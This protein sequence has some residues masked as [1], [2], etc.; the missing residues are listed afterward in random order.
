MPDVDALIAQATRMSHELNRR[1]VQHRK[2]EPYYSGECPLPAAVTQARLTRAYRY[3]MPMADAPWGSLVVDT[4]TDR[5][6]VTGLRDTEKGVA[7]AC[8]GVWQDNFMDAES[9]LAHNAAFIDGRAFALVWAEEGS[10]AP[11]EITLDD[12]TQMVVQYRDGSRRHREAALRRWVDSDNVAYATLYRRDGTYKFKAATPAEGTVRTVEW[13]KYEVEGE[14]WPIANPL[15]IVNAVELAVNRRLKPGAF[16][17]ARGEYEHCIGL[18]DRINLLTFLG[19]VVAFWMGFPLRGVIGEKIRERVLVD[20]DGEPILDAD[21]AEQ[22][23]IEPPFD[24]HADGIFQLEDPQ[25]KLAEF[26]AADRKLLS[27]YQELDQLASITKTPRHY[28]PL[29]GGMSNIA[30]DTI[31]ANEGGLTAKIRRSHKPALSEGWEEVLRIGGKMLDTPVELSPRAEL[32]WDDH[33][34]RSLAER[35][36]AASKLKD[37]LPWQAV[38]EMALNAGS[39]Q[40]NRWAAERA[41]DPLTILAEAARTPAPSMNGSG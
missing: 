39:D 28:F 2:I 41:G 33:E 29:E 1:S 12:S 6:E 17:Y 8:W 35:A 15:G 18:I 36:D 10:E 11:P 19:L 21:G 34:S 26:A 25:A 9:K 32:Q 13:E 22:S 40:I 30:A 14:D 7:D 27:V 38:A 5:L 3:L 31:R 37:L 23:E 4:V 24:P 20:D 16:G